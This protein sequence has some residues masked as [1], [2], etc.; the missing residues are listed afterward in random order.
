MGE[1]PTLTGIQTVPNEVL[2]QRLANHQRRFPNPLP[3]EDY[4]SRCDV[5]EMVNKA[6][7]AEIAQRKAPPPHWWPA[8]RER[9]PSAMN[10]HLVAI[11]IYGC[12]LALAGTAG[13]LLAR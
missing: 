1:T 11:A 6:L 3:I 8:P 9:P 2:F 4:A 13:A 7:R 12:S 5:W 10:R